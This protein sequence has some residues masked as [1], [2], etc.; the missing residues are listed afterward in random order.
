MS[1]V[2]EGPRTGSTPVAERHSSPNTTLIVVYLALGGLAYAVLQSLVAPALST[3]GKDLGASTSNV[4]WIITAY[5]LSASVLTPIFGRMGDMMGKRRILIVVMS[6]LLVGTVVAALAPNLAT[7][8]VARCLQ[9]AAG[10]VL[11]LSIGIVRDELPKD[12]VSVVIGL[13]SGIFGIGAGIGIVAAGPIVQHLDWHWL[14][15]LP[16]A[17][18][19]VGLAGIVFGMPESDVRK[20]GRLDLAGTAILSISLVALLLAVS[21]G[22][23]WGWGDVKTIGLLAV[24]V[25]A[26]VVFIVVELRVKAPLIDVRLFRIRGVWTAHVVAL[27]FGFAMY[28]TFVLVPT[29]LQ[30]PSFTGYGF[31]KTASQAG[32]FLL[33][34]VLMMIVVSP[35]AGALVRRTGPKPPLVIGGVLL[36]AAFVLPGLAHDQ[37]WQILVSGILTGAGIGFGLSAASNAIIESVPIEQTGEAI[38]ANTVVRTIGSSVGTAIIAALISSHTKVFTL[39]TGHVGLPGAAAFTIGFWACAGVGALAIVGALAAP[40]MRKR[41]ADAIAAGVEDIDAVVDER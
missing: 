6:L 12:R 36:T 31:G 25:V 17:L 16:L 11:P 9:G 18:I 39:P 1:R 2:T 21:E 38:S 10:A 41:R 4:S 8:I 5:L 20:P 32:L 27:V 34:T 19:V 3:I 15:W 30:L 7:L 33:P 13:L 28:G 37:V 24:G 26:L 23:T 14:F 29:L 22:E 35:V 40:G